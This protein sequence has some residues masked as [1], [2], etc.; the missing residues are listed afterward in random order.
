VQHEIDILEEKNAAGRKINR[1]L[2]DTLNQKVNEL[3]ELKK[4]KEKSN[5]INYLKG[6]Q[7][8]LN[9]LTQG[10]ELLS[11]DEMIR[12]SSQ[13]QI[14]RD[15]RLI[16]KGELHQKLKNLD[17][18]FS[19]KD[20]LTQKYDPSNVQ[21]ELEMARLIKENSVLVEELIENLDN[22]KPRNDGLKEAI[23]KIQVIDEKFIANTEKNQKDKEVL[24]LAEISWYLY[25]YEFDFE[26]YPYLSSIIIQIMKEKHKDANWDISGILEQ[27]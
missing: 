21:Y 3:A 15:L 17:S 18:Y 14:H 8:I 9:T 23:Q 19:G 25:N 26:N 4:E 27:L 13:D 6:K 10:Y 1:E 7:D 2:K 5:R 16:D 20:V 11:F 24:I 22:Y 12:A